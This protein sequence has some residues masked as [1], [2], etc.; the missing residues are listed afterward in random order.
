CATTTS[1]AIR[2]HICRSLPPLRAL[3]TRRAAREDFVGCGGVDW[4]VQEAGGI[5]AIAGAARLRC[6]GLGRAAVSGRGACNVIR[7]RSA[8]SLADWMQ[9]RSHASAL[10]V[11]KAKLDAGFGEGLRIGCFESQK[12]NSG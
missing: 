4:S 1:H 5:M 3:P 9:R 2:S 6:D 10:A 7:T 11:R 8:T 12:G